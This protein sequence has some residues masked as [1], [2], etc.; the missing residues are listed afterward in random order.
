ML[1]LVCLDWQENSGLQFI[2]YLTLILWPRIS[3]VTVSTGQIYNTSVFSLLGKHVKL[4]LWC[5]GHINVKA[6][7]P[8]DLPSNRNKHTNGQSKR[9]RNIFGNNF[10]YVLSACFLH[11]GSWAEILRMTGLSADGGK[12]FKQKSTQMLWA[13]GQH[14]AHKMIRMSMFKRAGTFWNRTVHGFCQCDVLTRR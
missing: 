13:S 1:R 6:V 12:I 9:R 2:L 10:K 8:S 14:R 3:P 11:Q 5:P 7:G 4:P